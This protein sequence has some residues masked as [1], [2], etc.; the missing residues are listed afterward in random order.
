M[1]LVNYCYKQTL[2]IGVLV[3]E[4]I[5]LPALDPDWSEPYTDMLSLIK[6]GSKA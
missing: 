3:D 5:F 6:A 4:E 1:K 2:R